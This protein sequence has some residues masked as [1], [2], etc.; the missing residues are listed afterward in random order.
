MQKFYVDAVYE[1]GVL[2]L[3]QPL[4][5]EDGTRV[6]VMVRVGPSRAQSSA[7]L[8]KWEGD[9]EVLRQI[10]EDPEFGG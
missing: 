2:K 5:V 3:P 6:K 1:N 9:P 8:L 10:A 7:G 4:P